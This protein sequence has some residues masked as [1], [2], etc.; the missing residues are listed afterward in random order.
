MKIINKIEERHKNFKTNKPEWIVVHHAA[1][2][3]N[4]TFEIIKSYHVVNRGFDTIGYH[5]LITKDGKIYQG[6]PDSMH[7]A[8]TKEQGM[9]NKSLGIC[10]TGDFDKYLP[11]QEQTDSL[12]GLIKAKMAVYSIPLGKI[13]PHRYFLGKP[14][15]KSCYGKQLSDDWAMNL[16]NHLDEKLAEMAS[17]PKGLDPTLFE[18]LVALIK[19]W[20]K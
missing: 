7:G 16:A 19:S 3:A 1:G 5:F 2:P 14:P 10:L 4:Q 6:R 15:Y 9:N 13:V 20:T 12:T 8:H 11:S 18:R 17:E